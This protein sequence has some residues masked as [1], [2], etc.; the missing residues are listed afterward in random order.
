M[1]AIEVASGSLLELELPCG[2]PALI[3]GVCMG[4]SGVIAQVH[5]RCNLRKRFRAP[6]GELISHACTR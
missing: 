5:E 1:F 6:C 4:A 3:V 2:C